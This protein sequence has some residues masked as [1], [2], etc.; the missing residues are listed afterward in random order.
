MVRNVPQKLV[1]YLGGD[2]KVKTSA[3]NYVEVDLN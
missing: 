3:I 1:C 2:T